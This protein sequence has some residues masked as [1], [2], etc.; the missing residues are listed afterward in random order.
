MEKIL[1]DLKIE[2]EM[3][4]TEREGMIAENSQR[5][6]L[7]QAMAYTDNDFEKV[8]SKMNLLLSNLRATRKMS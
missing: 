5:I 1:L 8:R 6:H 7:N 2:M 3:L 4:I